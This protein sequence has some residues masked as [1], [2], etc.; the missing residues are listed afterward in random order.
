M[1]PASPLIASPSALSKAYDF[2]IIGGGTAGLTV[3]SR[4]SEVADFNV[5][6]LEAGADHSSDPK[7]LTPGLAGTLYDDP[8]YDWEFKTVPQKELRGRRVFHPRGK[9]LG[10]TSAL[11]QMKVVY[12]SPKAWDTWAV[13]GNPSWNSRAMEPYQ[14]KFHTSHAP[15]PNVEKLHQQYSHLNEVIEGDDGPIQVSFGGEG[16][17][18]DVDV[19]FYKTMQTITKEMG[20]NEKT[21]GGSASPNSIDP[22]TKTR[23]WAVSAYLGPEVQKRK[24]IH[25]AT[26]ALVEK[27]LLE[28]SDTGVSVT[29]VRFASAGQTFEVK[30]KK[31]VILCAG[32][33]HSPSI[34][35]LSGIGDS[36]L[37]KKHGINVFVDNPNVGE[38]LQDHAMTGVSFEA[39]DG[40]QTA[41]ALV[42]DP[43]IMLGLIKMYEESKSGPLSGFFRTCAYAPSSLFD[44]ASAEELQ[45]I[46][47][48]ASSDA[49]NKEF[50]D[51]LIDLFKSED[52]VTCQYMLVKIQC[53]V[54]GYDSIS[55]IMGRDKG[56][57][58]EGNYIT[59]MS[60]QNHPFSKGNIH[61][62]SSSPYDKPLVDPKYLSH[63][64][65][66][67][68]AARHVQF[69]QKII[70]TPPLSQHFK[71]NG[72]RLPYGFADGKEPTLEE[73][74]DIVRDSL[75]T[76]LHPMG[77]CAMLPKEKGGVIDERLRVH[78]VKGLRVCDASIFPVAAKGNP[79]TAVYAVAE[80]G[81]DL[82]KEDWSRD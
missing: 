20:W 24:N 43:S 2:I 4:L 19:D 21:M 45:A 36:A 67:E 30:A 79:I 66:M 56:P 82:I 50:E 26:E 63:P 57:P 11:F 54:V 3:A 35:E 41:D 13:L 16:S 9:V 73:V 14:R 28:K 60:S 72:K 75:I 15:S 38:N 6:V 7:I 27:I 23:S 33:F 53:R 61:I 39:A 29:G 32:A 22:A 65:D 58:R 47:K 62:A 44:P 42:R 46:L 37:L 68:I 18:N 17:Y 74:K 70:S 34:L 5:L 52:G 12:N 80:R 59:F 78:G 25:I 1:T 51:A 81:A 77:T 55:A 71:P 49:K 10:G 8:K 76:H 31:E 69:L 48:K 64:L 40:V